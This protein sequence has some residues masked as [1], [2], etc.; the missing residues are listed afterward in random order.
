[1]KTTRKVP[2]ARRPILCEK[3]NAYSLTLKT[4]PSSL[5]LRLIEMC[6]Y[7]TLFMHREYCE[8]KKQ[9]E[10]SIRGSSNLPQKPRALVEPFSGR[11]HE[12]FH[13]DYPDEN[14][15]TSTSIPLF[16]LRTTR[17]SGQTHEKGHQDEALRQLNRPLFFSAS[18]Y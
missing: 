17:K 9:I 13:C 3:V 10:E 5:D 14:A 11:A 6:M 4:L 2:P 15:P 18:R 1:M 7:R 12:R 16:F 8:D